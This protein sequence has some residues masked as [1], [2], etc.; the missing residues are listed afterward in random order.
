[1]EKKIAADKPKNKG[2]RPRKYVAKT[3][4][5]RETRDTIDGV[6][7]KLSVE[8]KDPNF[9]Y[10]FALD[11]DEHGTELFRLQRA[12]YTFVQSD[13]VVVGQ[14]DVYK[15]HDVGSIVRVPA[16]RDGRYH[17]LM[18]IPMDWYLDDQRALEEKNK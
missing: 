5:T 12:G 16:G 3:G 4:V 2:G 17:Y 15:S 10:F 7:D 1:M 14:A 11:T 6:R 18:K 8:G 9:H 13:E